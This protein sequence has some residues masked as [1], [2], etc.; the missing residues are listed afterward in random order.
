MSFEDIHCIEKH[1]PDK[2]ALDAP[3]PPPEE[4]ERLALITSVK[5]KT[6]IRLKVAFIDNPEPPADLRARI[7][8]HMNAW[9]EF[10]DVKFTES[11][12]EP[13]VRI[14]LEGKRFW[15]YLGTYILDDSLAGQ[16]TMGLGGFTMNTPEQTFRRVVR[17]E[18]GHTLGFPHEHLRAE[19]INWID[20]EKAI[21]YF[22]GPPNVWDIPTIERNVLTPLP[23]DIITTSATADLH[24]V[25]CY[26]L[27]GAILKTG[28]P[29]ITGGRD[30][31]SIDKDFAASMYPFPRVGIITS[32]RPVFEQA[33]PGMLFILKT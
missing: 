31:S 9:S 26:P 33:F 23:A 12:N 14:T 4:L 21:E 16:A 6:P 29:N 28:A 18:T 25:M 17:H 7:V 27:P 30:I 3:N 1:L 19:V 10:C 24:S 5:W 32:E 2:Q 13:E 20:R 15:S 22:S 11:T 8:S